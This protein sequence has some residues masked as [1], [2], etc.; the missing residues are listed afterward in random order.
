MKRPQDR[1][2]LWAVKRYRG[3]VLN[4]EQRAFCPTECFLF[5]GVTSHPS[6]MHLI[7]VAFSY[8]GDVW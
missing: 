1:S 6:E 5:E 4:S 7:S 3:I 8:F 2:V